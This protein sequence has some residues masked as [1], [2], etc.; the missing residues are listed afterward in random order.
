MGS[1]D[2]RWAPYNK[3]SL[4]RFYIFQLNENVF[5]S[6]VFEGCIINNGRGGISSVAN[7]VWGE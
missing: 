4:A 7:E 3:F 1:V 5:E 2:A 6:G